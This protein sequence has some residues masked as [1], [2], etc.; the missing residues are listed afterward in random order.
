MA[1][2]IVWASNLIYDGEI[3]WEHSAGYT[4]YFLQELDWILD[5]LVA[6]AGA[7]K[8]VHQNEILQRRAEDT[9]DATYR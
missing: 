9:M 5:E 6:E 2:V 8:R 3:D 4:L 1:E 7:H